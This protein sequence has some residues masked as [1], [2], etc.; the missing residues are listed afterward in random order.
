MLFTAT[1]RRHK[2]GFS[3]DGPAN[4]DDDDGDDGDD[5]ATAAD[6]HDGIY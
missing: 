6:G 2:G 1:M 5:A 3:H 4:D